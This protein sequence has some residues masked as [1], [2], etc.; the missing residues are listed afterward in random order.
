[1]AGQVDIIISKQAM[2]EIETATAKLETLRLKVLE[3]NKAGSKTTGVSNNDDIVKEIQKTNQLITA[4]KNLISAKQKTVTA[5]KGTAQALANEIN[6]LKKEQNTLTTS[7]KSWLQYEMRIMKVQGKLRS[8]TATQSSVSISTKKAANSTKGFS[9]SL[10]GVGKLLKGG[11]ILFALMQLK[12]LAVSLVKNVFGLA[13]QFDSLR[14]ALERTSSSLSEAKMN[15][16]FMLKLSN[17]LGLSLIATTTRFIKFAAAAR[18]SGLAMKDVQKIFG[19]M[20][21]A[22]AVLGLRTDELSGV[23]LAL[24][25][26]LSKGKVTTEELRRQLGE[27]LPGAFGIM[28]ASLGVTLPKLDEMLKKGE[29]LSAEV[30][31]GFADAVEQA[32]GLET[33]D[34]VNTLVASQNRLTTAWQN[35]V[36]NITGEESKLKRVFKFILDSISESIVI[37]D[38]YVNSKEFF[39]AE[40]MAFGFDTETDIIKRKAKEL[41][42]ATKKEDQKFASL[43]KESRD[44]LAAA[45][46]K[47]DDKEA[48]ARVARAVAA[49]LKYNKELGKLEQQQAAKRFDESLAEYKE[50]EKEVEAIQLKLNNLEATGSRRGR[51]GNSKGSDATKLVA[52]R[53]EL[54]NQTQFLNQAEG[55]LNADRLL[56][57]QSTSAVLDPKSSGDTAKTLA[58]ISDLKNKA[59][60]EQLL[61]EIEINKVSI[62]NANTFGQE[63]I[64][65]IQ[66]N[67]QKEIT[68]EGLLAEDKITK[69]KKVADRKIEESNRVLKGKPELAQ[70]L[71]AIEKERTDT[72]FIIEQNS[73]KKIL[74]ITQSYLS[75]LEKETKN[76][77]KLKVNEIKASTANELTNLREVYLKEV[78]TTEDKKALNKKYLLDKN[79]LEVE[80]FNAIIDLRIAEE[81]ALA[82]LNDGNNKYTE[83]LKARIDILEGSKKVNKVPGDDTSE[84]DKEQEKFQSMLGYASDYA[85]AITDIATGIYD[86][87]IADIDREIEATR[88]KY[89]EMYLLA[90]GDAKQTR[91]LKIQEAEDIAKLEKKKRKLQRQ[92]AIFEK[93]NALVQVAI[94]T[95]VAVSKVMAQTGIIS[96][97]LIPIIIGLGALQTAAVLAQ[98]LPKFAKG[99]IMG[100]DGLAVVG[101]GGKQEVIR[102]P[103]GKL[104]LTPNTDTVVNLQKGTEIFS[105]V[106]KFNQQNPNEM[107]SMLHSA[108]LLASISLNQK[109]I[110]GMMSG[111]QQLDE[112]LL[113]AMLMNTKAVKKSA[114]N[115]YVKT[116]NIDIAHELWKNNLLN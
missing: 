59:L 37:L 17:D 63:M 53:K 83:G 74:G 71:I 55:R 11:G 46:D 22:G 32:F 45:G 98:P 47:L 39:N 58:S 54:A 57:E 101:D 33:V 73:Q 106:D 30:L 90:E 86:G 110:N 9:G 112:R 21:K 56:A 31:P 19:T 104:S 42:E 80:S 72:L 48:D 65:L 34:K 14:F 82:A 61:K 51:R 116:Q 49:V 68:I 2:A 16:A 36:K 115:T 94:N 113:D 81:K 66:S 3:V 38:S 69:A 103:D 88:L 85:N 96:P 109:N 95:A 35:F 24:E 111:K 15:S 44:A 62:S 87:K 100:H 27:R 26:M 40:F 84:V 5:I 29:L 12:D 99:G 4:Q 1:M 18:N 52:I 108:S 102:T 92:K 6:M 20:A 76:L 114:S 8:L 67:A 64:D 43:Q 23:F 91:L 89:D 25:Q 10:G 97:A 93:A 60:V 7:N 28:A 70:R 107:S 105:S 79:K 50:Q 78:E 77:Y 41:L 75:I 13:K